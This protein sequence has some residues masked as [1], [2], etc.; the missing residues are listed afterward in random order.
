MERCL[1]SGKT[2]RRK[3][4]SP[5]FPALSL[6]VAMKVGKLAQLERSRGKH[7]EK[8]L[9]ISHCEPS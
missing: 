8:S 6:T 5:I 1:A 4:C 9:G 7:D 2:R 3:C